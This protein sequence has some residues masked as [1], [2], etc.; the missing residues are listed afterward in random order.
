MSELL[1]VPFKKPSEVDVVKPLQNLIVSAY[2]SS[3][4]TPVDYSEA[5]SEFNK[6]RNSS[7]WKVYEKYESSLEVIYG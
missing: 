1:V 6:L 5:V 7:V 4:S 2:A 3:S